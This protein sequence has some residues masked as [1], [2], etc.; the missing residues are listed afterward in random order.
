MNDR[1]ARRLIYAAGLLGVSG[2]SQQ[3]LLERIKAM[4]KAEM[5]R[6]RSAVDWVEDYENNEGPIP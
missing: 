2:D 5:E 6:L 4:P 3:K 1:A